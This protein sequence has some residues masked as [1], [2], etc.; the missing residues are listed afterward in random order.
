MHPDRAKELFWQHVITVDG[1]A[2]W[3]WTGSISRGYGNVRVKKRH[4]GAHRISWE[5]HFG[6]IPP[7]LSVLHKCDNPSCCNPAHLFIGTQADNMR[8]MKEKGRARW[9][10]EG[11]PRPQKLTAD[12]VR[13]IRI[14]Y[15]NGNITT[16]QLGKQFNVDQTCISQ[17]VLRKIWRHV[18]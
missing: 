4:Y 1:D 9:G 5:I 10:T 3:G 14:L 11:N 13:E 15:A 17:I 16:Y 7:G 6:A 18:S 8:D 2:C 12:Q